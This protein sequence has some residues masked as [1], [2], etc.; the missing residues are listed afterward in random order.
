M[1]LRLKT[2]FGV[3]LIEAALLALLILTVLNFMRV[4]SQ[5]SLLSYAN[6]TANLF[7]TTTKDAIL[8][9]D[10][11][12]LYSFVDEILKNKEIVYVRIRG[13]QNNILAEGGRQLPTV[14]KNFDANLEDVDDDVYDTLTEIK[15][16]DTVYGTIELG[17]T[18][19]AIA[20]TLKD[21]R[22]MAAGI[23]LLEMLLV[24]IFSFILGTYLTTQIKALRSGTKKITEGELG[25][26]IHVKGSDEIAALATTFNQMST[27]LAES[28]EN[29][30][31]YK[32]TIEQINADLEAR[33]LRRTEEISKKNDELSA[34]YENLKKT[35]SQLLQA[36]KMASVGQL[37]AGVAH[38][39]NNPIGF[40]KSN[41]SSLKYY[42]QSYQFVLQANNQ[43][44]TEFANTGFDK[45]KTEQAIQLYQKEDIDYIND[46]IDELLNDSITG[47]QRVADIVSN[48]KTYS[49]V[50][51][52]KKQEADINSCLT[53]TLKMVNNEIKYKCKVITDLQPLPKIFCNPSKLNQVFTNLIVNAGQAIEEQ[54]EIRIQTALQNDK[55]QIAIGDNGKGIP[56][57]NIKRLFDPFF[58]T[59]PVGE[60]TG[61]GL[62]ISHGIIEE[63]GG[64]IQVESAL[65]VGTT[66]NIAL[67]LDNQS[68]RGEPQP[69]FN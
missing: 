51:N 49:H 52:Q 8:S 29:Q 43:T 19:A 35:Q 22:S 4:S 3:A 37:A 32:E 41:L 63:H 5:E 36:D 17:I 66:F 28:Y 34:A 58:T 56:E 24:A 10:L 55:I 39:I 60:G 1:S 25:Y 11:A 67:P 15:E 38:E 48:L 59:K 31:K 65:D 64:T 53:T 14:A 26:Q 54:G 45:D 46:D 50:D 27:R 42:I 40:I 13:Q 61:L 69:A 33:V 12:S 7:A 44:F 9:Y 18:T 16:A 30:N 21:T 62:S 68:S 2:I 20:Q 47:I 23:A 57:E 6:T